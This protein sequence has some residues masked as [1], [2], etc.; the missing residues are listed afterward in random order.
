M[1]N[2][3]NIRPQQL[4]R[5]QKAVGPNKEWKPKPTHQIVV[6][7]PG[8]IGT[9][10][11]NINRSA[12]T[13]KCYTES[14]STLYRKQVLMALV[15]LTLL[16]SKWGVHKSLIH[17]TNDRLAFCQQLSNIGILVPKKYVTPII[18]SMSNDPQSRALNHHSNVWDD[19]VIHSLSTSYAPPAYRERSEML[20]QDIKHL[21]F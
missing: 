11:V 1:A 16:V 20:V 7:S 12:K 19:D 14:I 15:S 9:S 13:A 21:F 2:H 10:T 5:S 18:R 3:Y 17:S 6:P 4:T 8:I